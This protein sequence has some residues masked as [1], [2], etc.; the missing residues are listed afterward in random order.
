V[1]T[2][3]AVLAPGGR[4]ADVIRARRAEA[5]LWLVVGLGMTCA[6]IAVAAGQRPAP[7]VAAFALPLVIVAGQRWLL[8]W[9]TMLGTILVVIL[10]IPIRRYTIGGGSPFELEPYRVLM[11]VVLGCWGLAL[12]ADPDV[13]WRVTGF[14]APIIALWLGI[15]MSIALNLGR[16]NG[17]SANVLKALTFFA[18]YFLLMSLISGV[19]RRG[20]Q[21]DRLL[22]LLVV[23]G[24]ILS[25][26]AL[27]EWRTGINGFNGLGHYLP[28]LHYQ[29]EG[30]AVIR[31]TGSRARASAQ[32]P[33]ALGAAL[34]ML[35]PLAI[36]L[37]KR[38]G[39]KLWLGVGGLLVLAALCTGSRTAA[40]MM[41][42]IAVCFFVIKRAEFARMLPHMIV[43]LICVQGVMPGT[44]GSFSRALNPSYAIKEQS[45]QIGGGSGRLADLGPSLAEWSRSPFVGQG[46]GTRIT[47]GDGITGAQILDD[48]WLSTLLELGVVGTGGLLW[49]FC[50]AIRRLARRARETT[51]AESWLMTGL[52]TSITGFAVGMLTF[53]AF[54]FIQ[55]TFLAF[56]MLAF[57]AVALSD[58]PPA[59]PTRV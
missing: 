3:A 40:V 43:L 23:G 47:S 37:H 21:L 9:Q 39:Q 5:G 11:A 27:V 54:A 26:F 35:V 42:A 45:T 12:A 14:G 52:A 36:Y 56:V 2:P 15:L 32:H 18:S 22:M 29:D 51:G 58:E 59:A 7:V 41:I 20:R 34:V 33:I 50:R 1:S 6:T 28:F 48:Q 4:A 46:F 13:R 30:M 44:L 49:L 24:G 53:D 10:F 38:S 31:G 55:V 16:V 19:T 17:N 8:A 25:V 57:A